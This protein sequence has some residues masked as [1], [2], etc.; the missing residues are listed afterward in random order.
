MQSQVSESLPL[1]S[2]S[3]LGCTVD[4]L[5]LTCCFTSIPYIIIHD[6]E[7]LPLGLVLQ[8]VLRTGFEILF[9]SAG[10]KDSFHRFIKSGICPNQTWKSRGKNPFQ[11]SK[12]LQTSQ[13]EFSAPS[14]QQ[15]QDS[16]LSAKFALK[17]VLTPELIKSELI[18]S[19]LITMPNTLLWLY[20]YRDATITWVYLLSL[21]HCGHIQ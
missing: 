4:V 11:C 16:V 20:S 9:F 21:R 1:H 13:D 17:A 6:Y 19:E 3:V 2:C 18:N 12:W 8:G 10:R 14:V 5:M 15:N 7:F